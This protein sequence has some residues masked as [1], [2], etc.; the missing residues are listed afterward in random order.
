MNA[1]RGFAS[2]RKGDSTSMKGASLR[3]R[4]LAVAAS[5]ALVAAVGAAAARAGS[6]RVLLA[7][8]SVEFE[9]SP[10]GFTVRIGGNWEFDNL[11]QVVSGLS[12]NILFI[13]GDSFIRLQYPNSAWYGTVAGLGSAI[14]A[15]LT[16]ADILSIE[17]AS[18]TEPRARFA[19]VEAQRMKIVLPPP[20]AP[21]TASGGTGQG[22]FV[23]FTVFVTDGPGSGVP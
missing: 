5:L 14:D 16:G 18:I 10:A 1:G 6:C 9:P 19:S 4:L 15:G 8:G 20:P 13:R 2:M 3:S 22:N 17:A 12:F 23:P 7:L 21:V 11:V